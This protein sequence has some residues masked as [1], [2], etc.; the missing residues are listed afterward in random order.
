MAE[1][2]PSAELDLARQIGIALPVIPGV[3][4]LAEQERWIVDPEVDAISVT[5][6]R[7]AWAWTCVIGVEDACKDG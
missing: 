7:V 3:L 4:D 2:T 1:V 5:F 6:L